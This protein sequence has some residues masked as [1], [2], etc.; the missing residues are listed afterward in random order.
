MRSKAVQR[1]SAT[2]VRR[3]PLRECERIVLLCSSFDAKARSMPASYEET[4]LQLLI[5][6]I[7][8]KKGEL[9][10]GGAPIV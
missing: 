7:M 4:L 8:V 1:Q 6:G 3:F 5:Y 9:E 2:A 10:L